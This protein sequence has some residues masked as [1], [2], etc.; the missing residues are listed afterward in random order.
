ERLTHYFLCNDV[1]KEKQV[2]L[3]ITLAGS[4]GYELLCNLCTP[5]KPAN[6]TLERLAEI[7]QKHL[8]PQPSNIAAINSKN[9]SR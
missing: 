7:M 4:E 9:A 5:K 1:P 3:F 2:S 8:Q 6:L